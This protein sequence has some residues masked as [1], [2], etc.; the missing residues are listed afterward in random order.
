LAKTTKQDAT[1]NASLLTPDAEAPASPRIALGEQGYPG[2]RVALGNITEEANR[3]LR[4]PYLVR[5]INEMKKDSAVAAALSFYKTMLGRVKWNVKAPV[6]ADDTLI[7]RTAFVRSCMND[8]EHSWFDFISS[9]MSVIDYGWCV[10]EKVYKR[11]TKKTSK[12]NDGLVGWKALPVRAQSSWYKWRFTD[13]GRYLTHFVQDLNAL[14]QSG[15]YNTLMGKY[16]AFVEI[17]REKFMLFRTSPENGNIEGAPALKSAWVAWRY[18]KEIETQEMIGIGRDLGGLLNIEIP[19]AYM[20]PDASPAHKAVY[21][22]YKKAVRNVAVGEQS[23]II[24]P[25][26]VDETT[27]AKLFKVDLLTSQGGKSYD[28][29]TIIQRYTSNILVCLFADLLQLGN[30]STGSFA[31]AGSKENIVTY[32][33]DFRLREI[34]NVLDN[35]LIKQT[36]E[37]NQ[38]DTSVLPEFVYEPLD[39]VDIESLGK[40][41]QQTMAVGALEANREVLNIVR[42]TIGA[43]AFPDDK[44]PML[45]YM[46][47]PTSRAGDGYATD[48]GGLNGTSDSAPTKDNT[49]SNKANK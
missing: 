15:Q 7:E 19:A 40:F 36:F 6:G 47:K 12:Y 4:M 9:M 2:L 29:S 44:E 5:E 49:A 34:K 46:N 22:D 43:T 25:S 27:K 32:A 42:T 21:E 45:E 48:T 31:L 35:D 23:G 41:I 20:S 11:R 1:L 3:K 38:W 30:N 33:L 14:N 24:T 13:D 26:D 16:G 28:T 17:P 8:M 18:K 10:N 37:M 39:S